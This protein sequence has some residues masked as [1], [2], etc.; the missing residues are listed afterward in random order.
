MIFAW[1][2][3]IVIIVSIIFIVLLF[4]FSVRAKKK[5]FKQENKATEKHAKK[6]ENLVNNEILYMIKKELN[7]QGKTHPNFIL[8]I[9][10]YKHTNEIDNLVVT[11]GGI[12]IIEVKGWKGKVLGGKD[13]NQWTQIKKYHL[14][15]YTYGYNVKIPKNP[16][17]QNNKHL[18]HFF[19]IWKNVCSDIPKFTSIVI[20][21][22]LTN[23]PHGTY[24]I[25]SAISYISKLSLHGT[26]KV[27]ELEN[28]ISRIAERYGATQLDHNKTLDYLK[29]KH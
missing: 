18:D 9:D 8:F 24:N 4:T 25:E 19:K 5:Q 26:Y 22:Y 1:L 29:Q 11:K 14:T 10:R 27:E 2:T 3:P 23:P 20:F 15:R 28:V 13:S 17:E 16:I 6:T 21:P 12:F 7:G